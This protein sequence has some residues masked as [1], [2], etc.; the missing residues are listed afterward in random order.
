MSTRSGSVTAIASKPTDLI[1]IR[2]PDASVQDVDERNASRS[3]AE[4]PLY[5]S[6][7]LATARMNAE[8]AVKRL[9]DLK[10]KEADRRRRLTQRPVPTRDVDGKEADRLERQKIRDHDRGKAIERRPGPAPKVDSGSRASSATSGSPQSDSKVG[11]QKSGTTRPVRAAAG[12]VSSYAGE[13]ADNSSDDDFSD[14]SFI[15]D[16]AEVSTAFH[17]HKEVKDNTFI[18]CDSKDMRELFE[19]LI[20]KQKRE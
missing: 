2:D 16:P 1:V 8:Q 15:D 18:L 14:G 3:R 17:F 5:E 13:E 4:R 6:P 9:E 12:K 20:K 7:E 11:Q 19:R 10:K